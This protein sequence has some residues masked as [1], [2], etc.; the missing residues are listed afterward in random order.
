MKSL[1][2][3][4][5]T[6]LSSLVG[7]LIAIDPNPAFA[8][9]TGAPSG[10]CTQTGLGPPKC[11]N[12]FETNSDT[13][14]KSSVLLSTMTENHLRPF[15]PKVTTA[16]SKTKGG[17]G[18]DRRPTRVISKPASDKLV[19]YNPTFPPGKGGPTTVWN[20]QKVSLTPIF[21]LIS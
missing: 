12:A 21:I 18:G 9:R 6:L 17:A 3:V 8:G 4:N 11:R 1:T 15:S 19:T 13:E 7:G 16:P 10:R 2:L 5:L 14:L 20:G